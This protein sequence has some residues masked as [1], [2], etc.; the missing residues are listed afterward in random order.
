MRACTQFQATHSM[1]TH[2]TLIES[3]AVGAS[4]IQRIDD[5]RTAFTIFFQEGNQY[6]SNPASRTA[7]EATLG[8][9]FEIFY[10]QA[11]HGRS[12]EMSRLTSNGAYLMLAPFL[13]PG[14]TNRFIDEQLCETAG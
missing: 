1:V 2:I 6:R 9:I 7:M 3:H 8:A 4:A 12:E 11:R 5:S 10:R 14:A 13:G